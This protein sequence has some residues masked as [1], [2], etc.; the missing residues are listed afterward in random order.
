MR[1]SRAGL[2]ISGLGVSGVVGIAMF[3]G[4]LHPGAGVA[5]QASSPTF[6]ADVAPIIFEKCASCHRAGA[7]GAMSLT[8][9]KE[10]RPWARSIKARVTRR[11]M[12]P[13][14]A[15]P[16]FGEYINDISLTQRQ[17]DLIAAWVDGGAPEGSG[18]APA[19]PKYPEGG[20]RLINGRGPDVIL[21]M[22]MTYELPAEGQIP[23][24]RVWD[25]NPFK[26]DVFIQALQIQPS[27]PSVTHHSALYG[28]QLPEGTTLKKGIGWKNGPELAYIPTYEDGSITNVLT[29]GGSSLVIEGAEGVAPIKPG[30][31]VPTINKVRGASDEDDERLMFYLPGSDFQVFPEGSAKRI[32]AS[33]ALMW[34]V[35]Y[36]PNGKPTTDRERIGLWLAKPPAEREVHVIRNGSGQHIIENQEVGNTANLPPIPPHAADWKITAI[37]PFTEDV[38]LASMQPHMHLRGKD[39][40][41]VATYPDGHEEILLSVPQYDFNWQNT[42]MPVKP[43]RL[44]AG[45][46]LKTV[47]HYNNSISNR[48]NPQPNRPALWSEQ[49]WDEMYNAWTEITYD[50]ETAAP[51]NAVEA[52]ARAQAA[53]LNNPI[54]TVV[55][56][57]VPGTTPTKW[58]LRNASRVAAPAP[59]TPPAR[60]THNL[61]KDELE[62][63]G[64]VAAGTDTFELVGVSDFVSAEESLAN[65]LRKSLYPIAR[66]NSTG[67]LA[68]GRRVAVKGVFIPGSPARVN[69]TSVVPLG[70]S[71]EAAQTAP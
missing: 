65:P 11:E 69:L 25:K 28:R 63:A 24:F 22:P 14:S 37:Q 2:R 29:A 32:R 26:E 20:W 27:D 46:V 64:K 42:Y 12:P 7:I 33:N 70:S 58:T 54:T 56:C 13:W 47:G 36:S 30:D 17:I 5:A 21:E 60:V 16:R 31:R 34:E 49:T 67:A 18:P 9:Y 52:R 59:T 66:V 40:T 3:L 55:G 19:L 51:V 38:T 1:D 15:D 6:N 8:S 10:V 57:A 61:S 35:H 45:T 39:M 71:C 62:S 50:H 68:P 4:S 23:V 53:S 41:Y 48:V 44:P 43:V